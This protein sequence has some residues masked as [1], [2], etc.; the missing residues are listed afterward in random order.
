VRIVDPDMY[1]FIYTVIMSIMV[2]SGGKGTLAGPIVG[3]L[4][5]GLLP[6]GMC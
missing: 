4:I 5:F 6:E 2:I 1:R 3:G